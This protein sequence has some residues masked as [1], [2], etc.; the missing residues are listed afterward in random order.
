MPINNHWRNKQLANNLLW[1]ETQCLTF[2]KTHPHINWRWYGNQGY[3]YSVCQSLLN[4]NS[5]NNGAIIIN[6]PTKTTVDMFVKHINNLLHENVIVAYLSINRYEFVADQKSNSDFPD[7]LEDCID[8]IV[9]KCHRGFRR[10]YTPAQVDGK[11]F[12]GVHGLDVFIYE[13]Y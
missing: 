6:T 13:N 4:F 10:L 9:S 7:G 3:F 2:L 5:D 11:H 1:Q 8:I 12:V